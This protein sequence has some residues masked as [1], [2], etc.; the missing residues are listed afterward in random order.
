MAA[1]SKGTHLSE[2]RLPGYAPAQLY[3]SS[4]LAPGRILV[5]RLNRL[6]MQPEAV[7]PCTWGEAVELIPGKEAFLAC[8]HLAREL[9]AVVP[10]EIDIARERLQEPCMPAFNSES[11]NAF[12]VGHVP[13]R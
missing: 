12:G 10:D 5:V 11:Q 2:R 8:Q 3:L 13:I 1:F 7:F 9:L 4:L 6:R